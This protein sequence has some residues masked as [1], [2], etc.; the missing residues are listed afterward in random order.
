MK[1]R[2]EAADVA[3]DGLDEDPRCHAIEHGEIL[4]EK[5]LV[6]AKDKDPLCDVLCGHGSGALWLGH[7]ISF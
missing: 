7:S 5:H 1:S 4:I 6:A 3:L 2:R